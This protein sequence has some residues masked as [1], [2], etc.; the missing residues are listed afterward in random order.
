MI[1]R[2]EI[3]LVLIV[4]DEPKN[5]QLI[6]TMLKEA[7]YNIAFASNGKDAIE[8]AT[9]KIPDLILLDIM[10]PGMS[11]LEVCNEMKKKDTLKN[12]PV[13]FITALND[14]SDIINGFKAGGV[15]YITKPFI[16]EVALARIN[17]HLKL[18][19]ALKKLEDQ[20][21]TDELTGVFNRRFANEILAKKMAAAKREKMNFVICYIDIDHLKIV[22][23]TYGHKEGDKLIKI[24]VESLVS[25]IRSSDYMFRMGGDEFMLLFP[26]AKIKEIQ[27]L[28]ERIKQKLNKKKIKDI[29]IDFSIGFTE[30]R[31][32]ESLSAE[33]LINTADQNMYK[34]KLKKRKNSKAIL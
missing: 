1:D 5:L 22:N 8:F 34:A 25:A 10:M 11:G 4:D 13:M 2:T 28:I 6:G 14:P 18:K 9:Q 20:A 3:P 23:D 12:I 27:S 7:E 16:K 32:D 24:V 21:V 26:K 30:Y 29:C 15:D 19:Q 31:Y 17:V 33:E